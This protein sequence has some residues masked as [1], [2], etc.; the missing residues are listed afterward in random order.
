VI[1]ITKLV[2]SSQGGSRV[3]RGRESSGRVCRG[4]E[5]IASMSSSW[6]ALV[7]SL[8]LFP[9]PLVPRPEARWLGAEVR[10][11]TLLGL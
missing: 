10:G 11:V 7:Q 4:R 1:V 5:S 9:A 2:R 6:R 8:T 3:R